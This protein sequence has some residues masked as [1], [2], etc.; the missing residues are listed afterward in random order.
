[1]VG[2]PTYT[3]SAWHEEHGTVRWAPVSGNGTFEWLNVAVSQD[4]VV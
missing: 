1:M 2:L 3:L 4:A